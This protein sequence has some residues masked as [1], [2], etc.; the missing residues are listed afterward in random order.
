MSQLT[1][2]NILLAILGL[3]LHILLSV[4]KVLK[5]PETEFSLPRWIQENWLNMVVAITTAAISL[6]MAEDI[7]KAFGFGNVTGSSFYKIHALLSGYAG[8][9]LVFR[10]LK[11]AKKP[12]Q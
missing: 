11:L 7:A 1:G 8:R 6:L 2:I 5:H 3:T 10:I 4:Q 12:K 9:D